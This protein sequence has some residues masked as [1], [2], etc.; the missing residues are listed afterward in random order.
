M[1][2]N[3]DIF[4]PSSQK[5][6]VWA[7]PLEQTDLQETK[8]PYLQS[9][10]QHLPGGLCLPKAEDSALD[11]QYQP[12]PARMGHYHHLAVSESLLRHPEVQALTPSSSCSIQSLSIQGGGQC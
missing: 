2:T 5:A 11:Q 9:Q 4:L 3:E 1:N 8:Y 12:A 6:G 10:F 7:L